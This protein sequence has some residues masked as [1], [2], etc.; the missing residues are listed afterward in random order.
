[1][2]TQPQISTSTFNSTSSSSSNS[3]SNCIRSL[4]RSRSHGDLN[5]HH[6]TKR[7]KPP[8]AAE[9]HF[10]SPSTQIDPIQSTSNTHSSM[11]CELEHKQTK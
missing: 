3:S 8:T 11:E 4:K 5:D 9:F 6:I 1:M 10:K 7:T 2:Q